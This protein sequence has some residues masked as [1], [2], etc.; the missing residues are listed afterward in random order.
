MKGCVYNCKF[1]ALSFCARKWRYRSAK[2]IYKDWKYFKEHNDAK[3][4]DINDS[5]FFIPYAKVIELLPLVKNLNLTWEANARSDTPFTKD[6]VK[7]LEEAGCKA[8]FFGFESMSDTVLGYI[9]KKTTSKQNRKINAMF[10]TSSIDTM[11][12]FIVGFPGET[13]SEFRKTYNYL[14]NEHYGHFNIYVFEFEDKSM[15]IWQDAEKFK[16]KV[17][18]DQN[19]G[20]EHGGENWSHIGMTSIEA[21][22]LRKE[23]LHAIRISDK[24]RAIHKSWQYMYE[25][26]FITANSRH[27]QLAVERLLD[28][29]AYVSV[30]YMNSNEI[31]AKIKFIAS[32][33]SKYGICPLERLSK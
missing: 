14:V 29:L 11:M 20:W 8:L 22:K 26:E 5:T 7:K 19:T 6:D 9:N 21:K 23:L 33:L 2:N 24:S 18:E 15:P 13:L 4:I 1:C 3:H 27:V 31:H 30:D 32:E 12:S 16:I 10:A 17:F 25:D 28:K